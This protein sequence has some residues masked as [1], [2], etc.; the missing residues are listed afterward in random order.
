[1]SIQLIFSDIDG[2][3]LQSNHQISRRTKE[4]IS[5]CR[6]K[7]IPFIL[8]SARMPQ[9]ILPIKQALSLSEPIVCYGGALI[10]QNEQVL[11]DQPIPQPVVAELCHL[12]TLPAT[13]CCL[14]LYSFNRWLVAQPESPWIQQEQQI[15]HTPYE[16]SDFSLNTL[17]PIHKLLCMGEPGKIM[18]VQ[19]LIKNEK[20]PV[21]VYR[22][23]PT[24]LEIT[25]RTVT[26]AAAVSF[27][28]HYFHV[29]LEQTIAF[30]DNDNDLD[31]LR[32][33]GI[34]IAM[35]NAPVHVQERANRIT[36]S[37]DQDGIA[38]ALAELG[39]IPSPN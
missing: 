26:K 14:S 5:A 27:I 8:V 9:G 23:K 34:G 16:Q 30:G 38:C 7:G 12:L 39:V 2:T 11:F 20:R 36:R 22:S 29:P 6:K 24:Y 21:S 1:M 17:P 10:Q 15:A 4:S 3:L 35:G 32:A 19:Q 31:M 18:N 25:E 13:D 28:G 33:A 37:N